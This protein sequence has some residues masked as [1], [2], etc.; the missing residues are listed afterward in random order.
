MKVPD[1]LILNA[2]YFRNKIWLDERIVVPASRIHKIIK[3]NH[4]A[5]YKDT[6]ALKKQHKS[7]AVN[8]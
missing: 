3:Q 2:H 4:N 7:Y 8:I 5:S 1:Q 6:G